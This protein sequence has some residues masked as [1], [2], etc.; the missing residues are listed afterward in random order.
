[1]HKFKSY[2]DEKIE[3]KILYKKPVWLINVPLIKKQ[4]GFES[5][6]NSNVE[7]TFNQIFD[8]QELRLKFMF[9]IHEIFLHPNIL[10]RQMIME[11]KLLTGELIDEKPIKV[12]LPETQEE[13]MICEFYNLPLNVDSKVVKEKIVN[14]PD[15]IK[16]KI[17][18]IV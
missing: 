11:K 7:L 16:S 18:W 5:K 3:R 15:H 9:L 8:N 2:Y 14:K 13:K 17:V 10:L 1:M 12:F 4:G 6:D